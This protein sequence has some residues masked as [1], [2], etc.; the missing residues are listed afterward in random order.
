MPQNPTNQPTYQL[1]MEVSLRIYLQEYIYVC[2]VFFLVSL[3][4][5]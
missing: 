5:Y 4:A 3:M 1:K 2:F